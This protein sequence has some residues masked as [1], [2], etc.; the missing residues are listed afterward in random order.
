[1]YKVIPF[2]NSTIREEYRSYLSKPFH[3]GMIAH[4]DFK[5][6]DGIPPLFIE[7]RGKQMPSWTEFVHNNGYKIECYG[8]NVPYKIS[9]SNIRFSFPFPKNIYEFICDCSRCNID[10]RWSEYAIKEGDIKNMVSPEDF[11]NYMDNLLE[12]LGKK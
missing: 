11:V 1:M 2:F 9:N 8:N 10:L 5:A 12:K 6:L 4:V 7:W 3:L